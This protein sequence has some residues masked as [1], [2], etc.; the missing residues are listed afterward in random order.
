[1]LLVFLTLFH[2]WLSAHLPPSEDELYYWAWAK[3]LHW[4]YFDHPP[5]VAYLIALS[6]KIF[7]DNLF[8][9]RFFACLE[10]WVFLRRSASLRRGKRF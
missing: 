10:A 5:M 7:G 1:M 9:I 8:G 4:S 2:F 3:D 6:T